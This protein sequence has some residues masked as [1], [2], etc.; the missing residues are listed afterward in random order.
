M[1]VGPGINPNKNPK[2]EPRAIGHCERFH[3]SRVGSNS[4]K[5]TFNGFSLVN[6]LCADDNNSATPNNPM[7]MGT[8]SNPCARS[9]DPKVKRETPDMG[10]IP[11]VLRLSPNATMTA[12][13]IR[14]EPVNLE[15]TNRPNTHSAKNSGGPKRSAD[16][17]NTG[18]KKAR[19]R[20][21]TEPAANE[22]TAATKRAAP[23]RPLRAI[24]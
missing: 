24:S 13:R 14:D 2:T 12:A 21:P 15:S 22:P 9:R 17:A 6:L 7:A 16:A 19:P 20:M 10:S 18:A 4:L 5:L 11:T 1:A 8:N 23:A 3:S